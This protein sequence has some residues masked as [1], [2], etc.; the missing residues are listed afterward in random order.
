MLMQ[1]AVGLGCHW[2]RWL[3]LFLTWNCFTASSICWADQVLRL[4]MTSN[5]Y[6]Y[7]GQIRGQDLCEPSKEAL[8]KAQT[9]LPSI[10]TCKKQ[11]QL[12][13]D[14]HNT[15]VSKFSCILP[16]VI[17]KSTT[18]DLSTSAK[19][20]VSLNPKDL[21]T[22]LAEELLDLKDMYLE[23]LQK[24]YLFEKDLALL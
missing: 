18:T 10:K 2:C 19:N 3:Y 24:N 23:D 14:G 9:F 5:L 7:S 11:L 20:L 13:F 12:R 1:V 22:S 6:R 4:S 8:F 21:A 15:I 17:V 16:S